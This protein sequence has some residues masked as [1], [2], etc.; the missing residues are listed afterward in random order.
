MCRISF[1]LIGMA[2]KCAPLTF[3]RQS[4]AQL[5]RSE[6]NKLDNPLNRGM[7]FPLERFGAM[8]FEILRYRGA[9]ERR[10]GAKVAGC[11][12]RRLNRL[13]PI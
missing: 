8:F 5:G 9:D 7:M 12:R 6:T 2:K 13:R 3:Q 1:Q 11:Q 10:Q 4:I